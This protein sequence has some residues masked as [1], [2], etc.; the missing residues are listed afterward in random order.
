MGDTHELPVRRTVLAGIGTAGV[1]AVLAGCGGG[2]GDSGATGA[3]PPAGA[4]NPGPTDTGSTG[5][6]DTGGGDTGDAIKTEDIPVGGGKVFDTQNVVVT[7]PTA[8]QFKAFSATCTHQG[9]QVATVQGGT[10][11]C[12]CHGSQYSIVDGSVK[13]GPAPRPL[14]AKQ[15]IVNGD[16]ITVS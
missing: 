9:C 1:A 2:S 8:G 7:Q 4:T 13:L 3:Q 15:A 5:G 14:P 6:G 16:Q 11:H 12:P 10:I